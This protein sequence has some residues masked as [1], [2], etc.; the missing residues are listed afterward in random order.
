MENLPEVSQKKS[1]MLDVDM[2]EHAQRVA[3]MLSASTMVPEHFRNNVGNCVIALNYAH[4]LGID[5][6][7][8][9][10]NIYLIHGKPAVMTQMQIALLNGSG[11]FTQLKFELSG[12]GDDR[13]CV[14][15]AKERATGEIVVG[16]PCTIKMAK[17]E[18]WFGKSGSKWKT[19]PELMLRYRAAAFFIRL[20][21]PE[22]TL[23]LSTTEELYDSSPIDITPRPSSMEMPVVDGIDPKKLQEE[24]S[25]V[26]PPIVCDAKRF[27]ALWDKYPE[28]MIEACRE[29][30]GIDPNSADEEQQ[31]FLYGVI[32]NMVKSGWKVK[33]K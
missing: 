30:G 19:L 29:N 4:R 20:N 21:A 26:Q 6:F 10:Q 27:A 22:T 2:F 9:L 13:Q 5:P 31:T 7:M 17:D 12:E 11:K 24:L 18:G 15:T 23:G 28:H 16:P 33:N 25:V 32:E 14:A 1:I 8:A 3:K